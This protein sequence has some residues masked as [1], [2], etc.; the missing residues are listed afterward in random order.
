MRTTDRIAIAFGRGCQTKKERRML[1]ALSRTAGDHAGAYDI[2][3]LLLVSFSAV[4]LISGRMPFV[5]LVFIPFSF[6]F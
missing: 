3:A 2:D 4:P 1:E 6:R 5:S